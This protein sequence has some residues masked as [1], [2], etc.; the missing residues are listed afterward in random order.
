[1]V[2]SPICSSP[3]K[4]GPS[5]SVGDGLARRMDERGEWQLAKDFRVGARKYAKTIFRRFFRGMGILR[6]WLLGQW[7]YIWEPSRSHERLK[8]FF[9]GRAYAQSI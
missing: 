1:M 4:S 8:H 7:E 3:F 2:N 9:S 6:M 5:A